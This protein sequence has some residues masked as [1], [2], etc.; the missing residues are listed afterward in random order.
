MSFRP[1]DPAPWASCSLLL[2]AAA[3]PTPSPLLRTRQTS[4]QTHNSRS[5]CLLLRPLCHGVVRGAM[6]ISAG[7][8]MGVRPRRRLRARS[9]GASGGHGGKRRHLRR[10]PA[11]PRRVL[12]NPSAETIGLSPSPSLSRS[13]SR[14]SASLS[15]SLSLSPR[16]LAL[17]CPVCR[18][19]GEGGPV[20]AEPPP[21]PPVGRRHKQPRRR[22]RAPRAARA[23]S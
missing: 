11:H 8:A 20:V 3:A 14:S 10:A 23:C 5:T 6:P 2:P 17:P 18:G 21:H 7:P 16:C 12:P 13:L 4:S 1:H 9:S 22:W 19:V 15:L